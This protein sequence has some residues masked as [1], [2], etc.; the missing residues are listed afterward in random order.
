MLIIIEK[1]RIIETIAKAVLINRMRERM[2][3]INKLLY[4]DLL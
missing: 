3:I 1:P 4:L 2:R